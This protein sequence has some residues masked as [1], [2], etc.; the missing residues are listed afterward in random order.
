ML[1]CPYLHIP[2]IFRVKTRHGIRVIGAEAVDPSKWR[3]SMDINH[4]KHGALVT[5]YVHDRENYSKTDR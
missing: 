1:I 3:I 4:K 5:A 2:T